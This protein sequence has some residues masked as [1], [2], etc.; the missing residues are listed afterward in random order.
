MNT[1]L[2][3]RLNHILIGRAKKYARH[4]N[5]SISQIVGD[6]FNAIQDSPKKGPPKIGPIT[7][8]LH[9]CLKGVKLTEEDYKKHLEQKFL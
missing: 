5:K 9:G 4:K 6:Y 7:H 8:Q 1:K 2:T 3:L